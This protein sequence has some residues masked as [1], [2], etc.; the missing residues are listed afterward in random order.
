[1]RIAVQPVVA[2]AA[3]DDGIAAVLDAVR[4]AGF[5]LALA[6]SI[7][8]A[9]VT[10]WMEQHG[11]LN[12]FEAMAT[13]DDVTRVKPDPELYLL[14]ARGLGVRPEHFADARDVADT[15]VADGLDDAVLSRFRPEGFA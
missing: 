14:A 3:T 9:W 13:R 1:M 11:L 6:T 4:P 8:R 15:V 5:R 10:R 7:D 12:H 2:D